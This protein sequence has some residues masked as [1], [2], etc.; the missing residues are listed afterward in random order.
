MDGS[1][2]TNP[3]D[4]LPGGL[5]DNKT[6]EDFDQEELDEGIAVELEHTNNPAI[7]AEIARD[8]LTEDK[9]YYEKLEK[10]EKSA[11]SDFQ[12]FAKAAFFLKSD[13]P[14]GERRRVAGLISSESIDQH[15]ELVLQKGLDFSYFIDK[16][17]L[18][19]DHGSKTTDRVG[20]PLTVS[21]FQKGQTLPDGRVAKSDC[22]WMEAVLLENYDLADRLWSLGRALSKSTRRRLGFSIEGKV[23]RRAGADGRIV[24]AARVINVAVTA[25]PVN[26]DTYLITLA[27]SLK[28]ENEKIA[29]LTMGAATPVADVPQT[30]DGA[31]ALLSPE[32][33]EKNPAKKSD[34]DDIDDLTKALAFIKARYP[35]L[36]AN[37]ISRLITLTGTLKRAG[38][39]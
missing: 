24:A 26:A 35:D 13:A 9:D 20:Y 29:S 18:N 38:V 8:H 39:L 19:D 34:D 32:S 2:A 12:I 30:G 25:C 22:H 28:E 17:W 16:G 21:Y 23:T 5:A 33:L 27:K 7:A 31:G 10:I 11:D 15:D 36:S 3:A 6:N 1:V 37:A 4:I 14:E